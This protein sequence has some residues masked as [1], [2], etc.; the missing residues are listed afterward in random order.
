MSDDA[1]VRAEAERLNAMAEEVLSYNLQAASRS[2]HIS[3]AEGLLAFYE[4]SL[5]LQFK[6]ADVE[7]EGA[8]EV[9]RHAASLHIAIATALGQ[10]A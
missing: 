9:F 5:N 3:A 6:L 2:E 8:L 1:T 7:G 10:R 4:R